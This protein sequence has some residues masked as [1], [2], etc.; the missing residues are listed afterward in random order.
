MEVNLTLKL[1]SFE[2][3]LTFAYRFLDCTGFVLCLSLTHLH[4][5]DTEIETVL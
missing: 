2:G 3:S 5:W 1:R 4:G